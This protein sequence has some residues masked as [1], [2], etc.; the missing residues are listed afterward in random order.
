MNCT[1]VDDGV[2]HVVQFS[3]SS[4]IVVGGSW[5]LVKTDCRGCQR[6]TRHDAD[7]N[8][9]DQRALPVLVL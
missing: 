8:V 9:C 3:Y 6:I 7:Y 5:G 2:K 4:F 1:C